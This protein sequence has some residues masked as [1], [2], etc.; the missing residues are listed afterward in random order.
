MYGKAS[1]H[2]RCSLVSLNTILEGRLLLTP[3]VAAFTAPPPDHGRFHNHRFSVLFATAF[4]QRCRGGNLRT[5]IRSRTWTRLIHRALRDSLNREFAAVQTAL[6]LTANWR[7]TRGFIFLERM[8][9]SRRGGSDESYCKVRIA[10][11]GRGRRFFK[12]PLSQRLVTS[13]SQSGS[14]S[15]LGSYA[16]SGSDAITNPVYV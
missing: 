6:R 9:V 10:R 3:H 5:R 4:T 14:T 16:H 13:H 15:T 7:P 11:G 8:L 12:N 2:W 1:A